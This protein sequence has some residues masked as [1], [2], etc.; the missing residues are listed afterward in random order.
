[1]AENDP[2]AV[3]MAPSEGAMSAEGSPASESSCC[4]R[5]ARETAASKAVD[6]GDPGPE[7][8]H[9]AASAKATHREVATTKSFAAKATEASMTTANA[10]AAPM[11]ATSASTAYQRESAM[12][13]LGHR[14][15]QC[16][17]ES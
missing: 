17:R 13:V 9:H 7:P 5:P 4:E 6:A 1:V 3:E 2:A 10:S 11:T 8:T 14:P 12:W 15:I 16:R